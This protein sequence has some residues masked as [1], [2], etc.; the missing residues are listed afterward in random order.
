MRGWHIIEFKINQMDAHRTALHFCL[1]LVR[2][3]LVTTPF[4]PHS[5]T[6]FRRQQQQ[7]KN[8]TGDGDN[9]F[10][11]LS[12]QR[13]EPNYVQQFDSSSVFFLF[14]QFSGLFEMK[15]VGKLTTVSS[16]KSIALQITIYYSFQAFSFFIHFEIHL[17]HMTDYLWLRFFRV[18]H[19]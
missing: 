15:Y 18:I 16:D 2:S 6:I 5:Y 17:F 14:V 8:I 4:S 3:L 11:S 12:R 7:K 13:T 9:L 10:F 19:C 1:L